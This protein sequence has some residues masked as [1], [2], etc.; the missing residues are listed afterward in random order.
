MTWVKAIIGIPKGMDV[1]EF[2]TKHVSK[3]RDTIYGDDA[4]FI[5]GEDVLES[6][7]WEFHRLNVHV[8]TVRELLP[9]LVVFFKNKFVWVQ[10]YD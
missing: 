10:V 5:N 4:I 6:Q 8:N 2:L 3:D 9:D 1:P 7:K